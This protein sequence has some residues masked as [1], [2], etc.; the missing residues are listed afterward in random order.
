MTWSSY[1]SKDTKAKRKENESGT[2]WIEI[3]GF[4]NLKLIVGVIYRHPNSKYT[5]FYKYIGKENKY[6]I[7]CGNFKISLL[8]FEK[9]EEVNG[10]LKLLLSNWF[11]PQIL[12]PT[13]IWKD[14]K[15]SLIGN[16]Y[17]NFS[18]LQ[19]NSGN[20]FEENSDQLDNFLTVEDL[21][22]IRKN[23][24]HKGGMWNN[25]TKKTF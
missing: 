7:L 3:N 17:L 25:L 12:G 22:S 18:N 6:N 15:E 2:I 4:N 8:N 1:K 19:C 24:N 10:C 14:Q 13:R 23:S 16:T 5:E 11:T 9:N 20:L 21:S